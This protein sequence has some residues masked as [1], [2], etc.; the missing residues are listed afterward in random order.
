MDED[1]VVLGPLVAVLRL[2]LPY[3]VMSFAVNRAHAAEPNTAA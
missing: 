1:G 3:A 2:V